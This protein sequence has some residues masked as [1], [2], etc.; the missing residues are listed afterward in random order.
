MTTIPLVP[1]TS[2]RNYYSLVHDISIQKYKV[3]CFCLRNNIVKCYIYVLDGNDDEVNEA[4]T[5]RELSFSFLVNFPTHPTVDFDRVL[6]NGALNWI[7]KTE[8]DLMAYVSSLDI[9]SE[10]LG[11]RFELPSKPSLCNMTIFFNCKLLAFNGF[12][13][14]ANPSSKDRFDFWVLKGW[15][16]L[17]PIWIRQYALRLSSMICKPT[18][19]KSFV[20]D[21]FLPLAI[22]HSVHS[23]SVEIMIQFCHKLFVYNVKRKELRS[24][25]VIEE[26]SVDACS[27]RHFS[28]FTFINRSFG[29]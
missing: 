17:K 26:E 2:S 29:S 14:Y 24:I 16:K 20:H 28:K 27:L 11:K 21:S 7:S 1:L 23:Y 25:E 3:V 5:W 18:G 4:P 8:T 13:C 6:C 9:S 12:L 15:D 19:L 22:Y 10:K